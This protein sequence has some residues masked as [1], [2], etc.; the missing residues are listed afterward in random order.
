MPSRL[1]LSLVLATIGASLLVTATAPGGSAASDATQQWQA[2]KGGT[3]RILSPSDFDHIDPALAYGA[4]SW[5]MLGATQLR[6]Y[7]F[8]YVQRSPG[9]ANRADGGDGDA[10]GLERRQDVRD[11]ALGGVQVLERSACD[12]RQLSA[13][14]RSSDERE[15]AVARSPFLDDVVSVRAGGT[16]RWPS[17]WSVSRPTFSRG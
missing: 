15:A 14:L 16:P 10:Q 5:E 13:R 7:Y 11:P 4:H 3:F 6:L 2:R 9:W 12:G 17:R 1:L 8:P